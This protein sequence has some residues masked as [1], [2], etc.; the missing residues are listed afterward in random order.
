VDKIIQ[1]S[2]QINTFLDVNENTTS[3]RQT[4]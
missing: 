1:W 3:Q 4:V 2:F